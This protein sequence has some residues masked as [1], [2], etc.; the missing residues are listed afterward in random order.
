MPDAWP[1]RPDRS[2]FK[3]IA[4][5]IASAVA[6]LVGAI[7]LVAYRV[8]LVSFLS[9]SRLLALVPGAFGIYVRRYWYRWTLETC[10]P[11]LVVDWLS[12]FK[13]PSVRVGRNVFVGAM[14]WIAEADL[15]DHVM[16]AT[17]VAVQGGGRTHTF[18]RTDIPMSRQ[19]SAIVKIV[20]GSDVWIGTGATIMANVA[21]GTVVGAG[22]VVTKEFPERSILAG[23]PARVL[24]SRS[25]EAES[26]RQNE[27][28]PDF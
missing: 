15:G 22:S 5:A 8:H 9:G 26:K 10:G 3:T 25:H 17:R 6:G 23:V 24:R 20:I 14:C 13:T 1:A 12:V 7:V 28:V 16:I 19:D 4:V 11:D 27:L 2:V 18:D 21:G